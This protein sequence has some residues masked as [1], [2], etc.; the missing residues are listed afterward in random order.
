MGTFINPERRIPARITEI[1]GITDEDVKNAP[2]KMKS[3]LKFGLYRKQ[4]S[5]RP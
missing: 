2:G 5:S 3:L 4:N 1:T